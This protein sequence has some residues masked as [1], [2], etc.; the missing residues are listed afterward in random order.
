[1]DRPARKR[2]GTKEELPVQI[3]PKRTPP[4]EDAIRVRAYQIYIERGRV[5][6]RDLDDWLQAEREIKS[7]R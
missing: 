4:I 1:M 6:G 2:Q 3:P 7:N 5:P